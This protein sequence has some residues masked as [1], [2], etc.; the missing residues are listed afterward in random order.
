MSQCWNNSKA[1]AL[2]LQSEWKVTLDLGQGSKDP[3]AP[4]LST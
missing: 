2:V 4:G 3:A 1:L